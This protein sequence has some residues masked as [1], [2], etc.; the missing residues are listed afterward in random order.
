M[1][2]FSSFIAVI[3]FCAGIFCL[4]QSHAQMPMTGAG[5]GAPA[6]GGGA[7]VALQDISSSMYRDS[8]FSSPINVPNTWL[9]ITSPATAL[10]VCMQFSNTNSGTATLVWDHGGTNQSMTLIKSIGIASSVNTS[11]EIWGLTNPTL[12]NKVLEL[13]T[14][15]ANA[16]AF[17]AATFK[18]ANAT[19]AT[20]FP[21]ASYQ[22]G[23]S[24]GSPGT[25]T[26]S[27]PTASGHVAVA[28]GRTGNGT[29][30][31]LLMTPTSYLF[32]PDAASAFRMAI[33]GATTASPV[34]F[35]AAGDNGG[36]NSGV[37][38]TD[39]SN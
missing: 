22:S 15:N 31:N 20:A 35:T 32:G 29:A 26:I 38:G 17:G 36:D 25:A 24:S 34:T 8:S 23:N 37:V 11:V 14:S 13:T 2:K 30:N 39:V 4:A 6:S 21:S 33:D 9:T 1:R 18:N 12:G 19:F 10:L 16:V 3:L 5:L 7:S 27:V 28:C